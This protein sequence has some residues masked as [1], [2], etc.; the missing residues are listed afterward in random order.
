MPVAQQFFKISGVAAADAVKL[1]L[2]ASY[3]EIA[4][5]IGLAE[6]T[7][8]DPGEPITSS[9]AITRKFGSRVRITY[10]IGTKKRASALIFVA[11][12]KE[13]DAI[14]NLPGKNFNLKPII[15][16]GYPRRAVFN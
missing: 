3:K 15:S 8:T 11:A 4:S 9:E 14:K 10:K 1:R 5:I 2:T 16:A 7:V 6:A 13:D 12:D